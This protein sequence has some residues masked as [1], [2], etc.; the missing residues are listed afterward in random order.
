[1]AEVHAPAMKPHGG[2][3]SAAFSIPRHSRGTVVCNRGGTGVQMDVERDG[4]YALPAVTH[5]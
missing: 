5:E 3:S 1:M 4:V 2:S